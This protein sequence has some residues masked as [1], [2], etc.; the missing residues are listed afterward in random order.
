MF[1]IFCTTSSVGVNLK[2][3]Q[4][5]G[6][7][8]EIG[9]DTVH[10]RCYRKFLKRRVAKLASQVGVSEPTISNWETGKNG[11]TEK[12]KLA[13]VSALGL[14]APSQIVFISQ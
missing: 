9:S 2:E 12:H 3:N 4:E 10:L 7:Y 11:P 5:P 13:L 6:V 1:P 14:G 8:L